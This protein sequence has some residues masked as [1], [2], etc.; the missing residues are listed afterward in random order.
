[1]RQN[2][3]A[4]PPNIKFNIPSEGENLKI[5]VVNSNNEDVELNVHNLQ[6]LKG[7]K[8]SAVVQCGGV[9]QVG[10]RFGVS[11]KVLKLKVQPN[12]E[13]IGYNI[14]EDDDSQV[15]ESDDVVAADDKVVM[16][17]CAADLDDV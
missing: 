11:F 12:V 16:A 15:V 3:P 2:N 9:W 1:M 7:G 13:S 5:K 14:M 8:L 6:A 17:P 4:Y 10:S